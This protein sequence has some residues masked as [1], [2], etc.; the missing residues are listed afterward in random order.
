[1]TA[2]RDNI[3]EDI[4]IR[5]EHVYADYYKEYTNQPTI[6]KNKLTPHFQFHRNRQCRRSVERLSVGL[7]GLRKHLFK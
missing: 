4:D 6:I 1:M 2:Y 5:L 7:S 3:G